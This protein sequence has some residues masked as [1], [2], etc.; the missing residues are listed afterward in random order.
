MVINQAYETRHLAGHIAFA[1]NAGVHLPDDPRGPAPTRCLDRCKLARPRA[2]GCGPDSLLMT[3]WVRLCIAGDRAVRLYQ[4]G[5]ETAGG[6]RGADYDLA[7]RM[8]EAVADGRDVEALLDAHCA[9]VDALFA[10]PDVRQQIDA[11][12]TSIQQSV[13]LTGDHPRQMLTAGRCGALRPDGH[14]TCEMPPHR[15]VEHSRRVVCEDGSY[16][17]EFWDGFGVSD[18]TP[19][20]GRSARHRAVLRVCE[21]GLHAPLKNDPKASDIATLTA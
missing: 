17:W 7:V 20:F 2:L 18:Q 5:T 14:A 4:P 21:P 15:A 11:L 8:L 12:V 3:T 13:D 16:G 6:G 9:S 19:K 1:I 10:R